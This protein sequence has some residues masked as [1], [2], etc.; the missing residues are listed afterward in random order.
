MSEEYHKK[1]T[2]AAKKLAD[3]IRS[4]PDGVT[5]A[6]LDKAGLTTYMMYRLIKLGHVVCT[7]VREPE[8]GPRCY[9][10]L[11]KAAK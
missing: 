10:W 2:L 4:R 3:F 8:R 5:A 1:R 6:D 11:W 7:Q 9:H